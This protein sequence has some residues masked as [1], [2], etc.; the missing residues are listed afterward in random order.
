MDYAGQPCDWDRFREIADKYK[1]VLVADGCHSLGAEYKGR[2]IGKF[3]D[4]TIFSFHPVK[5]ITTGEG[6]M[7][8]T[9]NADFADRMSIFRNHGITSDQ[10]A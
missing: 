2:K 4:I 6:G 1:L 9:D 10:N 7:I 3:A 8:T 5:H